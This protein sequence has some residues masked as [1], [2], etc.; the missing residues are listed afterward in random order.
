MAHQIFLMFHKFCRI[1]FHF[2]ID[3]FL[4]LSSLWLKVCSSPYT[5]II[6]FIRASKE[7]TFELLRCKHVIWKVIENLVLEQRTRTLMTLHLQNYKMSKVK[8]YVCKIKK[9]FEKCRVLNKTCCI[10]NM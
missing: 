8:Y 5:F 3:S 10:E 6:D 7:I 2:S 1:V 4:F 9:F